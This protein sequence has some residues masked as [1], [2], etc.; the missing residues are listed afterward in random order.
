VRRLHAAVPR[1][2]DFTRALTPSGRRVPPAFQRPGSRK[3]W[4]L[5]A[6]SRPPRSTRAGGGQRPSE[7]TGVEVSVNGFPVP[8]VAT[9]TILRA[10]VPQVAFGAQE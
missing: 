7:A 5:W 6:G 4:S 3:A 9:L 2:F 10:S 8:L 1:A